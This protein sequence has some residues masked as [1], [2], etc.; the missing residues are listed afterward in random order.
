MELTVLGSAGTFPCPGSPCSGY[1]LEHDGH[2][3]LL[4]AGNGVLG[5]LQRTQVGLLGVDAVVVSHLHGDHVLDLVTWLYARRYHPDGA[6]PHRLVV[7]GPAGTR[8]RL[9]AV[10]GGAPEVDEVY[11]FRDHSPGW[12]DVGPFRV[13]LVEAAHPVPTSLV[14]VEADGASLAYSADTG[15]TRDLVDVAEGVDA[16]LFEA[17]FLADDDNPP[18]VHLTGTD[19]AEHA[20]RADAR[21]LL[22][23]HLVAWNDPDQVVADARRAWDGPL[24]RVRPGQRFRLGDGAVPLDDLPEVPPDAVPGRTTGDQRPG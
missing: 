2:A 8:E 4:D 20:R 15:P 19:A 5:T 22:L 14:R 9:L 12:R 21:A 7:H 16:A 10:T 18:D 24:H 17:S 23:T 13:R 11:E 1:L 6:P 3:L